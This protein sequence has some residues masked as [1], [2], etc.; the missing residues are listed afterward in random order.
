MNFPSN[1]SRILFLIACIILVSGCGIDDLTS[2]DIVHIEEE[3]VANRIRKSLGKR[4]DA[5]ITK[6]DLAAVR[7]ITLSDTELN[8]LKPLSMLPN[9]EII[10]ARNSRISDLGGLESL[11]QLKSLDFVENE[12]SSLRAL[13]KLRRLEYLRLSR[14][15]LT[16][17]TGIENHLSLEEVYLR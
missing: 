14:N 15:Q 3:A 9:L 1:Y 11:F 10:N 7:H 2:D 17:L 8:S 6:Q 12:I 5:L 16:D 4:F 13:Q